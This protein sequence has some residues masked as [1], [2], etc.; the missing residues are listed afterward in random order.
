MCKRALIRTKHICQKSPVYL[1]KSPV[2]LQK[3]P[4]KSHAHLHKK[5]CMCTFKISIAVTKEPTYI[6]IW[7]TEA[8]FAPPSLK[9]AIHICKKTLYMYLRRLFCEYKRANPHINLTRKSPV[10]PQKGHT[11]SSMDIQGEPPILR[12]YRALTRQIDMWIGPLVFVE[13][14]ELPVYIHGRTSYIC[15]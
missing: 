1:Q 11:S 4:Q 10:C 13:E 14:G 6:W 8:L 2:Y 15:K 7:H 5:S 3:S 9:R 12:T